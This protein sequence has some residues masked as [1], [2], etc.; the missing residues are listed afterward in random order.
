MKSNTSTSTYT[1]NISIQKFEIQR[2]MKK[3]LKI[4][5]ESRPNKETI[6]W[7]TSSRPKIVQHKPG[8]G[9]LERQ[10]IEKENEK[11]KQNLI[12]IATREGTCVLRTIS[13]IYQL[14]LSFTTLYLWL[15]GNGSVSNSYQ[16]KDCDLEKFRSLHSR[17]KVLERQRILLD[18]KNIILRQH[19]ENVK[20]AITTANEFIQDYKLKWEKFLTDF[21]ASK[22]YHFLTLL[23]KHVMLEGTLT[24]PCIWDYW[25]KHWRCEHYEILN[26]CRAWFKF[27]SI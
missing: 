7:R 16:S 13:I 15:V 3:F 12:N 20:P 1:G 23:G 27:K 21:L 10:K 4:I 8:L 19:L 6:E 11:L 24:H 18:E 17:E 22:Y 2:T 14:S 9:F 25:L 5:T 26:L